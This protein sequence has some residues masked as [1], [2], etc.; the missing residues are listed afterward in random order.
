MQV[1]PLSDRVLVKPLAKAETTKSGIVIPETA[2]KER[3]EQGEVVAVGPGKVQKDGTVRPVG[4][5]VGDKVMFK[6]YAPTEVKVDGIEM[7]VLDE[8]DVIALIED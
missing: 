8:S 6:S 7:F 2:S 5:K 3:P 4:L 1:K